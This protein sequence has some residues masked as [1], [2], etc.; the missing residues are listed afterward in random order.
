MSKRRCQALIGLGQYLI[1]H[2][3][4]IEVNTA[5]YIDICKRSYEGSANFTL[6]GK[7][8]FSSRPYKS[9]FIANNIGPN[10]R[11]FIKGVLCNERTV[12]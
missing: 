4:V 10:A 1:D 11:D 6:L 9:I 5:G 3:L 2:N 8:L 12:Y 7:M